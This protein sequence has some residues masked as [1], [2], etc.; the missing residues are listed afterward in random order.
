MANISIDTSRLRTSLKEISAAA[1]RAGVAMGTVGVSMSEIVRSARATMSPELTARVRAAGE[2]LSASINRRHEEEIAECL[3]GTG[4][5]LADSIN[6]RRG[7]NLGCT[8]GT[9]RLLPLRPICEHEWRCASAR[10]I[11]VDQVASVCRKCESKQAMPVQ[12]GDSPE[13]DEWIP[14]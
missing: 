7:G 11:L 2:R 14:E 8:Q 9:W 6:S 12:D 1:R 5:R 3:R 10:D 4:E 13:M